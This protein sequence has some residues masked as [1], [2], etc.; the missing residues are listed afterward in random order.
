MTA[1]RFGIFHPLWCWWQ[2]AY[3]AS[4]FVFAKVTRCGELS[5]ES[6]AD[7]R[8]AS[9]D[10]RLRGNDTEDYAGQGNQALTPNPKIAIE[11]QVRLAVILTKMDSMALTL[12]LAMYGGFRVKHGMT[13][14]TVITEI[15]R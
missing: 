15:L 13:Y 3:I 1:A 2:P 14:C 7:R 6:I 4:G 5:P 9:L 8:H 11:N 10:S 12:A